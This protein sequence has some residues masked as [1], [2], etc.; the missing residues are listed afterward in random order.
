MNKLLEKTNI[1]DSKV[2]NYME[3]IKYNFKSNIKI[4]TSIVQYGDKEYINYESAS[5]RVIY[6]KAKTLF[7][8]IGEKVFYNDLE[9]I[10]VDNGDIKES[11]DKTI[12]NPNQKKLL[13]ENLA[14]FS[15]LNV[16]IQNAKNIA[17]SKNDLKGRLNYKC[18]K[19]YVSN[20][21][22]DNKKYVVEFDTRIDFKSGKPERHF[23]LERI[24]PI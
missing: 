3:S 14:I 19:Y 1:I 15:K 2:N 23:I 17:C 12:K 24:Y 4:D 11:I 10:Y 20:V 9:A 5:E 6:H 13:Y 18:Y 8:H 22:I 21:L 16:I 7:S